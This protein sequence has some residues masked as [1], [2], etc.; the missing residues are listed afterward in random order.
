MQHIWYFRYKLVSS[1][2]FIYVRSRWVHE[3]IPNFRSEI[4]HPNISIDNFVYL[5]FNISGGLNFFY[6]LF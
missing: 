1:D 6:T 5:H 2:D 4:N 3:F